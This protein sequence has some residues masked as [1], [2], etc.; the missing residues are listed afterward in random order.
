MGEVKERKGEI[1]FF[2]YSTNEKIAMASIN[3]CVVIHPDHRT[4]RSAYIGAVSEI[5]NRVHAISSFLR[6]RLWAK[7]QDCE[8][9]RSIY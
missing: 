5:F 7:E 9:S 1:M 3:P 4:S 6:D 2:K 8:N